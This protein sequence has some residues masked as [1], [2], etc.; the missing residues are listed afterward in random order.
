MHPQK[1]SRID[2]A[3]L[4]AQIVQKIGPKRFKQY[5]YYLTRFLSHKLTKIE[6]DR[7]CVWVLG[8][9]NLPV[10]NQFIRSILKNAFHAKTPPSMHEVG[11]TKSSVVSGKSS[12]TIEDG[13]EQNGLFVPNQTSSVPIWSNGVV[14]PMSPRKGRSAIRD[15]KLKDRPSPL[16]YNE[17]AYV[18]SHQSTTTEDSVFKTLMENGNLVPCDYQRPVQHI[19]GLAEQ[20]EN[21]RPRIENSTGAPFSLRSKGQIEA[22]VVEDG[23]EV[24][25]ASH[26]YI[27]RSSL[28]APLGIPFCSASVGGSQKALPSASTNYDV[29]CFD[30]GGLSDTETLRKR[31]EQIALLQGLGGVSMECANVLNNMLDVYLKRLVRSSVQLVGVSSGYELKR[32]PAP[33]H[34]IQSKL[35][36]GM[37]PSNHVHKQSN[38]GPP[39]AVQECR[40]I[41]L[42]DFKV[43]ME[44]NPQQLG[45]DWPLLLEKICMNAFEE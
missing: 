35:I 14:L 3:D 32:Q 30:S 6:F 10:H 29:F 16:G 22:A 15:R 21:G 17:K 27:S 20:S 28:V 45:E 31:M 43:A 13:H 19:Q 12:P 40:P 23:E 37:L 8:R 44:L 1:Y 36:N 4:K 38:G 25:Q 42:L 18:A 9:E 24:E 5:F 11:P 2:V 33:K 41:S 39:E 34:Q 26:S 7:L